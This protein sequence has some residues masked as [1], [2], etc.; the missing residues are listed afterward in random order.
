MW[1]ESR[2][3]DVRQ[4]LREQFQNV[5]IVYRVVDKA[6]RAARPD[7]AHAAQQPKLMRRRGLTDADERRDVAHAELPAGERI[8]DPDPGRIAQHTERVGERF[9]RPRA[10]QRRLTRC[11]LMRSFA[12]GRS[13]KAGH[14]NI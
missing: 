14:L 13:F 7:Q 10:H 2:L 9:D 1:R 11:C 8:E 4:R 5:L 6:A 12:D 3:F